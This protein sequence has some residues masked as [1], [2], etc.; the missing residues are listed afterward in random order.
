MKRVLVT[1]LSL[2][3]P[4]GLGLAASWDGF[5]EGRSAVGPITGFDPAGLDARV[6][7]ELP[8][9]LDEITRPLIKPRAA[10][11]M[12]RATRLGITAGR[13]A[14]E[15]ASLNAG[16][17]PPD[18]FGITFGATGT[19]YTLDA[20]QADRDNPGSFRILKNMP[21]AVPA[22]LSIALHARGPGFTIST[23]CSSSAAAVAAGLDLIR[24]G[25]ADV[26]LAGGADTSV[27]RADVWGFC[28]L[29]ALSTREGPPEEASCPFDMRRDGFVIGEGA[30]FLVLE[31]EGFAR[32][33]GA[34]ILAEL[35]GAGMLTE[36]YNILSPAR[37][38]RGM[39]AAMKA[40]LD[41]GAMD[42]GEVD[43]INAHGTSTP[44]NDSI[45]TQAIKTVFGARAKDVP[46]SSVKSM[47]GHSLGA[48]GALEAAVTVLALS[49]GVI[50]P[51]ANYQRPDP[52]CDLDY[53]PNQSREAPLRAALSNAF[54]F[55]GHNVTLAF[56]A[57]T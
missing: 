17:V 47:V 37:D 46:V 2:L 57:Y 22:Y 14:F 12:T 32:A 18:R 56:R 52:D 49:R 51:T 55:G 11:Q 50:P 33:R 43:Y 8:D 39:A 25:R 30:A 41:D 34:P 26:V 1:G 19:G 24:L 4:L 48:A 27:N 42:P 15:A 9:G 36:G 5:C 21:S 23:A 53:V 28:E 7:A 10:R 13:Q 20:Q 35:A 6:A 45:E 40:A 16:D 44:L 29:L 31:E 54:A 3:T 38:G